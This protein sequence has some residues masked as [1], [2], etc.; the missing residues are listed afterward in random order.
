MRGLVSKGG[1]EYFIPF[2]AAT[3]SVSITPRAMMNLAVTIPV[4]TVLHLQEA[5]VFS[6]SYYSEFLQRCRLVAY[7]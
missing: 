6:I 1:V 5:H 2:F 7:F 4:V 3:T